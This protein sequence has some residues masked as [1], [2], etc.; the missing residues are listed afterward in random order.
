MVV[1]TVV[2]AQY[3]GHYLWAGTVLM[4]LLPPFSFFLSSSF[5]FPA[6]H[7]QNGS[8]RT[9]EMTEVNKYK[10]KRGKPQVGVDMHLEKRQSHPRF[11]CLLTR[12][13]LSRVW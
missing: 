5:F 10:R 9:R 7:F 4:F 12:A 6:F 1:Q 11:L 13:L 8:G 2:R 3:S